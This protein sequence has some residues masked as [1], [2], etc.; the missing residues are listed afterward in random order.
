[1]LL[2]H[3]CL[4][5]RLQVLLSLPRAEM[6][7]PRQ[8]SDLLMFPPSLNLSPSAPVALARSLQV[9]RSKQ[10][11]LFPVRCI[12]ISCILPILTCWACAQCKWVIGTRFHTVKLPFVI[13]GKEDPFQEY[14]LNVNRVRGCV[15]QSTT[16]SEVCAFV[17]HVHV[18]LD[19]VPTI[20]PYL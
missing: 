13:T 10:W 20:T 2:V 16:H 7:V 4:I 18:T 5:T 3:V 15:T 19:P 8:T 11:M 17:L 9:H 1:M 6:T 12:N 14:H